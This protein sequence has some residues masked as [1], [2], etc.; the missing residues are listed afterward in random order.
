[1]GPEGVFLLKLERLDNCFRLFRQRYHCFKVEVEL[2]V[3]LVAVI[4]G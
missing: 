3:W 2:S 1:M 4:M